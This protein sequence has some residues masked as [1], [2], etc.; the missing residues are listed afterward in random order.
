TL[1]SASATGFEANDAS[2]QP[3][4]SG[5]GRYVAF[6][7]LAA[8]LVDGDSNQLRDVFV[9]DRVT[10][11]T[12]RVSVSSTGGQSDGASLQPS[13]SRDGRFVS[14]LSSATALVS[15]AASAITRVY[16][17]DRIAQITTRPVTT[18]SP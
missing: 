6:A 5:D 9:R 4:L 11:T 14:F 12:T 13:I 7:S 18:S 17:R 16:V 10:S 8:N 15:P 2:Q 3:A 1:I